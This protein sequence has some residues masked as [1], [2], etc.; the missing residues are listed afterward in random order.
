M[1]KQTQIQNIAQTIES[2]LFDYHA[3]KKAPREIDVY[4]RTG[5]Y[6]SLV[7]QLSY[8][9]ERRYGVQCYGIPRILK[10]FQ[11][12]LGAEYLRILYLENN[13][14]K[15]ITLQ[16]RA[17]ALVIIEA[18]A[19]ES[20]TTGRFSTRTENKSAEPKGN[21]PHIQPIDTAPVQNSKPVRSAPK[22][23]PSQAKPTCPCARPET[24]EHVILA[25][26]GISPEQDIYDKFPGQ[27]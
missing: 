17:Q 23:I 2:T 5:S 22:P 8:F 16:T 12:L 20:S 13:L 3:G 14:H 6:E 26:L 1:T 24:S 10:F 15:A 25:G 11:V 19:Y 4:I 27:S 18:D 7:E 21:T 9:I